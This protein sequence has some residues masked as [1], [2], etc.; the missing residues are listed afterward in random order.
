MKRL[1]LIL[2]SASFFVACNNDKGKTSATD[3][4]T[5]SKSTTQ[6]TTTSTTPPPANNSDTTSP[7][8]P[9]NTTPGY[10]STGRWPV[11][12]VNAF[13]TNCVSSAVGG[14]MDR[15]LALRYC[16]CMQVKLETMYPDVKEASLLTDEDM[17]SPAMK[18]II[19][20]CLK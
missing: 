20:D 3:K 5:T 6:T 7:T 13:V 15:P 16:E 11:S 9:G 10:T 18:R 4:D 17:Q 1:S 14:G 19:K 8:D 12:E 2:L